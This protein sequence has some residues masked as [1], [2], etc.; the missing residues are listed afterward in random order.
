MKG[1]VFTEFL[2]MVEERF[3]PEIADR[4]IEASKLRSGGAYTA[5]GTYDYQ[6][7]LRLVASLS[8]ETGA[9][10]GDLVRSFGQH[11]FGRFF[12]S[13]PQFFEGIDNAFDFLRNIEKYVHMEVRKLY[14]DAELPSFECSSPDPSSLTMTYRSTRPFAVFAEGLILGC[15]EHFG[16]SIAVR[17]EDL[18][19]T[20]ARF[21]LARR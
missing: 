8:H 4:I 15:I 2:E 1:I 18:S 7:L 20:S 10:V 16:E 12:V 14:P 19:E 9:P 6:E 17:R 3:S 5:V 11:L 21:T 13:D